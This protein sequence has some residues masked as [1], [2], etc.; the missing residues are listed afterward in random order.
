MLRLHLAKLVM[1]WWLV[2]MDQALISGQIGLRSSTTKPLATVR[3]PSGGVVVQTVVMLTWKCGGARNK[4]QR[5]FIT[6]R[7]L[8]KERPRD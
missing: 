1:P 7:A 2:V 8:A 3:I 4:A 5:S 6:P